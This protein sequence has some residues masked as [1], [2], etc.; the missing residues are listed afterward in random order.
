MTARSPP[1]SLSL[2]PYQQEHKTRLLSFLNDKRI[3]LDASK[4]GA[5]KT[6]VGLSV[7]KEYNT[8]L[9]VIAPPTLRSGWDKDAKRMGVEYSFVSSHGLKKM[10]VDK[11]VCMIIDEC[12]LFKNNSI[13]TSQLRRVIRR[14]LMLSDSKILFMSATPFDKVSSADVFLGIC[15]VQLKSVQSQMTFTYDYTVDYVTHHSQQSGEEVNTYRSG[16]GLIRNCAYNGR[17][18]GETRFKAQMFSR[19]IQMI[20]DSLF[21]RL[22]DFFAKVYNP[23]HSTKYI[24]MLNFT[25]HF[26]MFIKQYMERYTELAVPLVLNGACK[27]SER[28][29]IIA[30]FQQDNK[31][32]QVLLTSNVGSVGIELDDKHGNYPRHII[33]LPTTNAIDFQ[34]L[35]GRVLRTHTK[36][37]SKCTIIQPP[38]ESTYFRHQ[39]TRKLSVLSDFGDTP[40][41]R[42]VIEHTE[43]CTKDD[44]CMCM[45][46]SYPKNPKNPKNPKTQK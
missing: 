30:L 33:A 22:W 4:T 10:R 18:D 28:K 40:V 11:G 20:H 45:S 1:S 42:Q 29:H 39:M 37:N 3:A 27:M 21:P 41:F 12:H 2:Y 46:S 31:D 36:S 16:Y 44:L 43:E 9:M 32:H 38:L 6:I 23:E 5:G 15:G 8:P 17:S 14:A 7:M 34:Q 13:R 25:R 24:I 26:N 35:V 19:G